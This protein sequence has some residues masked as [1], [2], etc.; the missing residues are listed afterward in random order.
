M[1]HIS[2]MKI[3]MDFNAVGVDFVFTH[4][5]PF[6]VEICYTQ[7]SN[8]LAHKIQENGFQ[9]QCIYEF[10][11]TPFGCN[12]HTIEFIQFIFLLNFTSFFFIKSVE[13]HTHTHNVQIVLVEANRHSS[14]LV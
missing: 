9:M 14:K 5:A 4:F 2:I 12:P 7:K 11:F 8:T 1:I 10:Y 3:Q 13:Q 6:T